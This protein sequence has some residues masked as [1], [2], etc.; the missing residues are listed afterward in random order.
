MMK[1]TLALFSKSPALL[2]EGCVQRPLP[3][4]EAKSLFSA[5][6]QLPR[7]KRGREDQSDASLTL[8]QLDVLCHP[9]NFTLPP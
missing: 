7:L 4:L 2:R 8:A 5:R 1:D 9:Q 3:L 6:P